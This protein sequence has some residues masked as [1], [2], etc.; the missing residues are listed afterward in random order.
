MPARGIEIT[1][2]ERTGALLELVEIADAAPLSEAAPE[3]ERRQFV[4]G[5]YKIGFL[6]EDLDQLIER[7]KT[8]EI[9][10]RNDPVVEPD[11]GLRSLQIVDPDGTIVQVFERLED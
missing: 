1:L 4:H 8:L 11:G 5:V 7:L 2:L 3:V 9:A 6:V 10:L